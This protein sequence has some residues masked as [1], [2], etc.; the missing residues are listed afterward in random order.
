MAGDKAGACPAHMGTGVSGLVCPRPEFLWTILVGGLQSRGQALRHALPAH[1]WLPEEGNLAGEKITQEPAA[2]PKQNGM[3]ASQTRQSF[4]SSFL[5]LFHTYC[6]PEAAW[7]GG[8]Y[9]HTHFTEEETESQK[10]EV[11][12][13]TQGGPRTSDPISRA[14]F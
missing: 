2:A 3:A 6:F 12:G 8:C 14:L 1:S 7:S 11:S 13:R 9:H 4:E 10:G 5:K